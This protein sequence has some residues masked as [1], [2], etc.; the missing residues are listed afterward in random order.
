MET[1][2]K[3]IDALMWRRA[4]RAFD[5]TKKVSDEDLKT[6]LESAILT[7]SSYGIEPWKFIVVTNPDTRSALRAA[8]YDQP[9]ISEASHLVV[10][11]QRTDAGKIL[12][13]LLERTAVSQGKRVEELDGFKQMVESAINARGT[14]EGRNNWF[15]RQ[16]YIALGTMIETASL[17]SI[18]NGPMEGFDVARVN[19]ILGLTEKNL[20]AVTMLTLGYRKDDEAL[21]PKVRRAYD[22]VVEFV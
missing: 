5:P 8:G 9:K 15:A 18:D 12:S 13:E 3:I 10:I 7:P 11:A 22:D 17:L 20:T 6:I 16:T 2:K 14:D 21:P 4:T 19:E 1:N